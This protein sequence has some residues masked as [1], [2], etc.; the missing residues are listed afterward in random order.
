MLKAEKQ[1]GV[2]K[3]I[4]YTEGRFNQNRITNFTYNLIRAPKRIATSVSDARENI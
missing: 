2:Q 1:N 3:N 4:C